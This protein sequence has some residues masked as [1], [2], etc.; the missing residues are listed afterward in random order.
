MNS[1]KLGVLS[2][3]ASTK[4]PLAGKKSSANGTIT[5]VN[6]DLDDYT[7]HAP[8]LIPNLDAVRSLAHQLHRAGQPWHDVAFGWDAEYNPGSSEPPP[9][10][11]MTFT[12]ADFWIGDG[13][14]WFFALMWEHGTDQPPV[15]TVYD[16]NFV[17]ALDE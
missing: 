15:E 4:S 8:V 14:I 10:S 5:V 7:V 3:G 16:K 13:A 2:D 12:P 11:K 1:T 6:V 17:R 9:G